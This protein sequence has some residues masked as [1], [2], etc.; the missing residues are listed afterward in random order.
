MSTTQDMKQHVACGIT[1]QDGPY[2]PPTVVEGKP[3]AGRWLSSTISWMSRHTMPS[4]CGNQSILSGSPLKPTNRVFLEELG[5]MLVTPV[6]ARRPCPPRS[7]AAAAIVAGIQQSESQP[8]SK[9]RR[10][11]KLC[12]YRRR[13][14]TTCSSCGKYVCKDHSTVVCTSCCP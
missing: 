14:V 10:R 7:T 13:M 8:T 9:M 1:R 11:Y 4:S 6:I 3:A 5:H 12:T 2:R